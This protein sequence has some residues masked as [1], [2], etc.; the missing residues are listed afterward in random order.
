M[1]IHNVSPV[2]GEAVNPVSPPTLGNYAKYVNFTSSDLDA[3]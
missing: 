3:Q 1:S 2:G